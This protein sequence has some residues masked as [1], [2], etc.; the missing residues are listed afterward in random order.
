MEIWGR[1]HAR[2]DAALAD[3]AGLGP[4]GARA[5]DVVDD[6]EVGAAVSDFLAEHGRVD[7]LFNNAGGPDP[8]LAL[9]DLSTDA[10]RGCI[11][12]NLDS[13]FYC[14]RAVIPAMRTSGSGRIINT[15]SMA[16][17]EG[18]AFQS[19]YSAA[20]AGVRPDQGAG[21]GGITVNAI[22]PTL[23]ETPLALDAIAEAPVVFEAIRAKIRMNRL[24][25]PEEAVA[26]V[27][28][29]ALDECSLTTGFAFDLSGGQ[30]NDGRMHAGAKDHR[31]TGRAGTNES[32]AALV[33]PRGR[34]D[35]SRP[36][37]RQAS[38]ASPTPISI[39]SGTTG[40]IPATCS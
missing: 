27:A 38:G 39:S 19:G 28:W 22:V 40:R 25:Q 29:I 12:A 6:I 18:K 20:K 10:W 26:L 11:A 32:A 4:I 30:P 2:L 31:H 9:A 15:G 23:F 13:T 24:D 8:T 33:A 5:V 7:I 37:R 17:K 21:Q 1:S 35:R 14:C 16:G 34:L 3:L 36:Y